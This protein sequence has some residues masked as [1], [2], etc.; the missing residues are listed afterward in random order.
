MLHDW[1]RDI[2]C[3]L[4]AIIFL[5]L[6]KIKCSIRSVSPQINRIQSFEFFSA[7][8]SSGFVEDTVVLWI[9]S[10]LHFLLATNSFAAPSAALMFN[11]PTALEGHFLMKMKLIKSYSILLGKPPELLS[12][13]CRFNAVDG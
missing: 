3:V 6:S 1:S 12:I 7:C 2:L 8:C 5:P 4:P 9:L 11:Q 13:L 10:V